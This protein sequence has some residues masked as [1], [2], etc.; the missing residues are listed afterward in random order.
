MPNESYR[1]QHIE[2]AFRQLSSA[3]GYQELRTPTF[4]DTE[5]FTRSSG[6]TS[7]IVTKQMYSFEDK[8]GRNITLKPE[9]TAPAMRALIEHNL[10]PPG[11]ISRLS[12][13][14]AFYRY[15]RPQ[16]GRLR[17]LHQCGLE[18][19]GSPSP[20]ADAEIIEVSARFYEQLGVGGIVV[21]LNSLGRQECRANYSESVLEYAEPVLR[22]QPLELRAR[23]EKNPLR[24]LD[25]KDLDMVEALRNV[26]SILNFLEPESKQHFD[27][28]QQLLSDSNVA[29]EVRPDIV[30]GLDYYTGTVFE[31]QST[32]LGSQSALCGGGRY[33]E[34]LKQLGGADLPS[35][36][37]GMG[38]ERLLIVLD[39]I[40]K[41]WP[42]QGPD[43]VVA[44]TDVVTRKV[45]RQVAGELRAAGGSVVMDPDGKS[46]KSQ[47]RLADKLGAR[48]IVIIGDEEVAK[49]VASV[50]V[51][52]TGEQSEV[53][54]SQIRV[55]LGS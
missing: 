38:L 53:G 6:D 46:L 30:R 23:A 31:I 55:V 37:V 11:T 34:L 27:D 2:T 19:V 40:G 52:A 35:V 3:Y 22:D 26:P 36:G 45:A 18:L 9:G 17:E 32:L 42:A 24:L 54:L 41:A 1:W 39:E 5:L 25:S 12:Y 8:G 21:L 47:M 15:E 48:L 29:F 16:K 51:L 43:A 7:E 28:V 4:E 33:D 14:S 49:G 20:M 50:K 13:I 10:C 44:Y